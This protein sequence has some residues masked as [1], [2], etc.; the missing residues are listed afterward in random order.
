VDARRLDGGGVLGVAD[1]L[2]QDGAALPSL[3]GDVVLRRSAMLISSRSVSARARAFAGGRVRQ[4][5][6]GSITFSATVRVGSSW[7]VWN[8]TPTWRP[9]HAASR[10]SPSACT[11]VPPTNTPPA[12]GRS[13]PA[14][15]LSSVVLPLPDLPT[16]ATHAPRGSCSSTRSSA[17]KSPPAT[18]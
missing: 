11:G 16:M 1:V 12:V 9:R 6:I 7:K 2:E 14:T 15:R 18:G 8:T 3:D 17:L 4:K 10:L 5:S 13:I